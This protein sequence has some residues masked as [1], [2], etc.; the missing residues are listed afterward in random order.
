[1][2][3]FACLFAP[4]N[5]PLLIECARSFSPHLEEIPP[6]TLLFDLTGLEKLFGTPDRIALK[7]AAQVGIPAGIAIASNPD[8]A[9]HAARGFPHAATV[10]PHGTEAR[11]LAPLSV[12]LLQAPP[13]I[14]ETFD[15]WGI[16]KFGE[17]AALPPLG[18]SARLG[19]EG[20]R[21]WQLARGEYD[22][23]LHSAR[24]P[25]RFA[26]ELELDDTVELLEPLSF[27]LSSMLHNICGRLNQCSLSAIEIRLRLTLDNNST[28]TSTLRFPVPMVDPIALL[29]LLQLDLQGQPPVAPVAKV[30]LEAEP[31]RPRIEQH[32]LFQPISP[33]PLTME[34]TI[35]R[36][37][38]FVGAGNIGTPQLDDTH[39][40]DAFQMNSFCSSNKPKSSPPAE[41]PRTALRRFR[42]P[43]LAQVQLSAGRP[44][45]VHSLSIQG[46]VLDSSGPWRTS[47]DWWTADPWDRDEWDVA[48]STGVLL[49]IYFDRRTNRWFLDGAYD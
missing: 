22:R 23:L 42:P 17:L 19:N 4:G 36:I 24:D 9:V 30:A 11:I 47:G 33:E 49:R 27:I 39:R 46:M 13:E 29:K 8:A 35:A 45:R 12:N 41:Q 3:L 40:P 48:L 44:V 14:A 38:A 26:E 5:L 31:A 16:R 10:I 7:I 37:A 21:L 15:Q 6:D 32:G 18:I 25:L 43:R 20:I 2:N 34:L 28:H 1:M